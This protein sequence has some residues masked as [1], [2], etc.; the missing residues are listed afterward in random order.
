MTLNNDVNTNISDNNPAKSSIDKLDI[1][2]KQQEIFAQGDSNVNKINTEVDDSKTIQ[3]SG[4][5]SNKNGGGNKNKIFY[6]IHENHRFKVEANNQDNAA[7]K[8][9]EKFKNVA[10]ENKSQMTFYIQNINGHKK[11]KYIT[12]IQHL[13]NNTRFFVQK[14]N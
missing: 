10:K 6:F 9:F 7:K 11:Y 13:N 14:I 8:G 2:S 1:L 4:I 3:I 12:K 5:Y